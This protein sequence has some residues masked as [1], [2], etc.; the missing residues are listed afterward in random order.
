M[1][2]DLYQQRFAELI[3]RERDVTG[4]LPAEFGAAYAQHVETVNRRHWVAALASYMNSKHW[5]RLALL[6]RLCDQAVAALA[7]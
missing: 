6:N 3:V 7:R 5:I 4:Q 2:A 1:D